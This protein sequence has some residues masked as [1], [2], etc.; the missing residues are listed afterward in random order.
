MR[1]LKVSLPDDLRA[2]LDKA[3]ESSGKSLGDEI[4]TRLERTF[5]EDAVDGPTRNLI[6]AVKWISAEIGR[7][8]QI[9]WYFSVKSKE[10]LSTAL[11]TWLEI[12][13]PLATAGP[14]DDT[15]RDL[16]GPDDPPTLGRAVARHYRRIYELKHD[17]YENLRVHAEMQRIR[18]ETGGTYHQ[19]KEESQ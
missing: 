17:A 4:R 14:V 19:K 6:E 13:N 7:Q 8:V 1:Q 3:S 11:Q 2:K 10:A 9:P 18:G 5:H 15:Q 12:I 16:F